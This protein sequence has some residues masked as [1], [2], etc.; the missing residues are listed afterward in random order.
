VRRRKRGWPKGGR[1][2]RCNRDLAEDVLDTVPASYSAFSSCFNVYFTFSAPFLPPTPF[3]HCLH[4]GPRMGTAIT[5]LGTN[6]APFLKHSYK[7][8]RVHLLSRPTVRSV[9][10]SKLHRNS[11]P[12]LPLRPGLRTPWGAPSEQFTTDSSAHLPADALKYSA[13]LPPPFCTHP[14]GELARS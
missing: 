13:G 10:V 12:H 4:A 3:L 6:R 11:W 8:R 2:A 1:V 7:R 5:E 14:N 9:Q